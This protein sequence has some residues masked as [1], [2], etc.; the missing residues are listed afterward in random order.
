MT[1]KTFKRAHLMRPYLLDNPKK[2]WEGTSYFPQIAIDHPE[3]DEVTIFYEDERCQIISH[4]VYKGKT[5]AYSPI[6]SKRSGGHNGHNA[7]G[8][9]C[10][11][12]GTAE[13]ETYSNV[14][15]KMTCRLCGARQMWHVPFEFFFTEVVWW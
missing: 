13:K 9:I 7:E 12:I 8:D 5:Y 11:H 10:H 6:A 3:R 15:G 14:D 1:N 2:E 4:L